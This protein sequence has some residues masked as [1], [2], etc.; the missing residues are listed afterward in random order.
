MRAETIIEFNTVG[1]AMVRNSSRAFIGALLVIA[2]YHAMMTVLG[3]ARFADRPSLLP[4]PDSAFKIFALRT[5]LDGALL[6][7]GHWL[8][9]SRG[10]ASRLAYGLMGGAATGVGYAYALSNHLL[11]LAPVE[12]TFVTAALIPVLVGLVAAS[13]YAQFAGRELPSPA[14]GPGAMQA[15]AE[16]DAAAPLSDMT[17]PTQFIGPVR[18][19]TSLSAT[20]IASVVPATV[21]LIFTLP[22]WIVPM[23][24]S[25]FHSQSGW[26]DHSIVMALPVWFFFLL[27]LTTAIPAA[28]AVNVAHAIA[29]GLKRDGVAAYAV[30]G[31][32]VGCALVLLAIAYL[33]PLL[34]IPAGAVAGALSAAIYRVFAGLE[35]MPLP[36]PVMATDPAHLVGAD[37][38]S[39]RGHRVILDA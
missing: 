22:L 25:V 20:L 1:R 36:E 10:I 2:A 39:R 4:S 34:V 24:L 19:R 38:P 37:H 7:A 18:V 21:F 5:A 29:R 8:L 9:R 11:P 32:A 14:D 17:I 30:I 16:P 12:G 15:G 27:L 31:A 33:T 28:I 6:Y 23:G 3:V 13:I 26:A 35:P